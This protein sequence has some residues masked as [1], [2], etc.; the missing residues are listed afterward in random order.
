MICPDC[1]LPITIGMWPFD[2]KGRGHVVGSFFTGDSNIHSSQQ[3]VVYRNPQT[4]ETRIP[5]RADTPMHPKYAAAGYQRETID[6]HTGIKQLEKS[7]GVIHEAGNYDNSGRA[8]RDTGS[9]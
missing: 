4:G 7:K 9:I 1:N 3:V 2:C 8:E 5:G 6:T